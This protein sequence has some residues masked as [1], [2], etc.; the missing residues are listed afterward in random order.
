MTPIAA[1]DHLRRIRC[2]GPL[3][4]CAAMLTAL[5][6]AAVLTRNHPLSDE[7]DDIVTRGI[8][9]LCYAPWLVPLHAAAHAVDHAVQGL[10]L[11]DPP[12]AEAGRGVVL[13]QH[14]LGLD[15]RKANGGRAV[16][17]AKPPRRGSTRRSLRNPRTPRLASRAGLRY[18]AHAGPLHSAPGACTIRKPLLKD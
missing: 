2:A 10:A 14:L 12:G 9:K 8:V 17:G 7:L 15:G 13:L 3:P 5:K 1:A 4:D 11:V 16:D 6:A 18:I